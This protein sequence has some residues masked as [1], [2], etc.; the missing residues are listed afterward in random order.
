[1]YNDKWMMNRA[2]LINFWY[3]DEEE[4]DFLYGKLLLRGSNGSGKSVTMQSFIPLLLDGNKSPER[5][6]PF[7]SRARKMENYLLGEEDT[8]KDESTGYIYMEFKKQD[9]EKYITIGMGL[10]AKRGKGLNSWGFVISDGRRIGKELFLYKNVG[11]KVPLSKKELK[12]RIEN[13]GEVADDQKQYMSLVNRY[14]FGF[15]NIDDYDELIKLLIQL[16][17]PKLSKDF[18]PTVVYEIMENSLQPL[19]DEDLR[20]MS[21]AIENMDNIKVKLED[22]KTSLKAA[23]QLEKSYDQ[24]NRF[25]LLEKSKDFTKSNEILRNIKKEKNALTTKKEEFQKQHDEADKRI[26]DLEIRQK[27]LEEKKRELEK[28][29]SYN[30]KVELAK[31]EEGLKELSKEKNQKND[32]LNIK[33]DKERELYQEIKKREEE[34]TCKANEIKEKLR[35]MDELAE[36]FKFHEEVFMRDEILKKMYEPYDFS[37]VKSQVRAYSERI[38]NARKALEEEEAKMLNTIMD[39]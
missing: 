14:L 37:Y 32:S 15:D 13:G 5:L 21:E 24:Y 30:I 25:V 1:M 23:E 22:L 27:T 35:E 36:A 34:K 33:L 18:K 4:F 8:G 6:D 28:H 3:Y 9:S 26:T 39:L 38:T 20:P 29:D 2:G 11:G 7:G 31:L 19:S 10:N 12:N 16:R 17:T